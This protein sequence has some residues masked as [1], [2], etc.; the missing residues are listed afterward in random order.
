MPE[1]P[2]T[3]AVD[4]FWLPL[5]AGDN[6]HLVRA[7]GRTYERVVAGLQHRRARP[8]FHSA[9]KVT[10]AGH[11]HVIEMGP[12]WGNPAVD[13]GVVGTGSVGL[14]PLG[15]LP[16]FRYEVRCWRDGVLPDEAEAVD[17]PQ[18]LSCDGPAARRVVELVPAC[19]RETWGR[20]ALGTGDMWNSNSLVSWV[21]ERS[22][23]GTAVLRPPDGGRAPGWQAGLVVARR[24]ATG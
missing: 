19:P 7:S 15:R 1:L 23:H 13:R 14:A 5:G 21:L 11:V 4:L 24:R 22:G 20:D 10:V 18:R 8:L 16:L 6:T 2:S 3:A 17:S 12:V 9:L